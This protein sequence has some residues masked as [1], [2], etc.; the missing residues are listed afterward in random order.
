MGCIQFHVS[1]IHG[2]DNVADSTNGAQTGT[3]ETHDKKGTRAFPK[4]QRAEMR[5]SLPSSSECKKWTFHIH[6][7][8]FNFSNQQVSKTS[9]FSSIHPTSIQEKSGTSSQRLNFLRP[10]PGWRDS[11]RRGCMKPLPRWNHLAW[12]EL[13]VVPGGFKVACLQLNPWL[14]F[15]QDEGRSPYENWWDDGWRMACALCL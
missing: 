9:D 15:V 11:P 14:G 1:T 7:H 10:P 5:F 3:Q 4:K 8:S 2:S 6:I 13:M 12:P